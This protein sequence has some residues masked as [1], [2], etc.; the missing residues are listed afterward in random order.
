MGS[1]IG[2]A[3]KRRTFGSQPCAALGAVTLVSISMTQQVAR[4][5][6]PL[7]TV[8]GLSRAWWR[9][10]LTLSTSRRFVLGLQRERGTQGIAYISMIWSAWGRAHPDAVRQMKG[11]ATRAARRRGLVSHAD[12]LKDA[13]FGVSL[14]LWARAARM[15]IACAHGADEEDMDDD[16]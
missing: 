5:R 8:A 9:M 4:W 12:L 7:A 15:V 14:Q 3:G 10:L 1:E 6:T 11:L 13:R 2:V 16:V